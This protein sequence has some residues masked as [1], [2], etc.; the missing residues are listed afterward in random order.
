MPRTVVRDELYKTASQTAGVPLKE[1]RWVVDA[2]LSAVKDALQRGERVELRRFGSF[3]PRRW[4]GREVVPPNKR[5]GIRVPEGRTV[6][7]KAGEEL[8]AMR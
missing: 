7:F 8:R 5:K 6:H 3:R 2:F 4:A 1:T